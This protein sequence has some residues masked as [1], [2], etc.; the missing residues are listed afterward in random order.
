[1]ILYAVTIFLS[2]FLLFQVQPL[3]AK[4]IL[5]WFGG[6]SAVWSSCMLFF[7]VVLLGGYLYAHWLHEKLSPRWQAVVHTAV[8]GASLLVLPLNP[9]ASWKGEALRNPSW[10]ILG[11]LA[12]AIG[13]PYFVLSTTSPLIQAWYAKSHAGSVPYRLFALSNL[14]SLLALVSYPALVE[15]A[16]SL[17]HQSLA[18]SAGYA[19]FAV[20]CG[21]TGWRGLRG[22]LVEPPARS[23][24][25]DVPSPGWAP[26]LM[27]VLLPAVASVLLL[28]ITKFLTQDVAAVPFLWILPLA[29]YL[30]SFI[31]CFDSPR[32]YWRP[33][34]LALLVP[35]LGAMAYLDWPQGQWFKV[36]VTVSVSTLALFVFC[37]VC[38]GEMVRLKPHPRFLTGFYLMMSV[39]GAA[40]GVLVGMVAP[41]LFNAAYELPAGLAMCA[42]LVP[43]ALALE[44]RA[45]LRRPAGHLALAFGGLALGGYLYFLG[46]VV[47]DMV[48]GYRVVARNFYGE[49]R[50]EQYDDDETGPRRK[51]LHGIINHGE[52]IL[53]QAWRRS[54]ITYFCPDTGIG[55]AMR[56]LEGTP[57]RIGILGLGCGTL[58]TY[59][60]PGDVVRIYEIN[61]LV[62]DLAHREFTNIADAP[63][64]VET[65]LG[66]GR[67][68]LEREAPRKFDILVMDAFSGDSVPVHLI[69]R[70]AF[71]TYFR[72][73]RPGGILA[74]NIS[75]RY[76]DLKPV[77][78]RAARDVGRIALAFDYTADADD[79][80]CFSNTW[81]LVVEPETH[82]ALALIQTGEV[83]EPRPG[84]RAWTDDY[85]NLLGILK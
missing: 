66:D 10:A 19:G 52:Q 79:S 16:L 78:A 82:R 56:A 50:V 72:H 4:L 53:D 69:T 18:W 25:A 49:L 67:L 17:R 5:P 42:V 6:T 76:L 45:R 33:V 37:M 62:L 20:L 81:A 32:F 27:W 58:L 1:M 75:N 61:P 41:N 46:V 13:L 68:L 70:E 60:R 65:A 85:S 9:D 36:P 55:R 24:A 28:A 74:V 3:I 12:T 44:N 40:G 15:P 29:V 38:H 48:K 11:L 71:R 47:G 80:I 43:S 57:R 39:G 31:L 77:V 73:L 7:Q 63:A 2:A 59:S 8:L 26:R 14:A 51:L 22:R 34:F 83:I 54:P 84:F 30:L 64:R 35:A 23:A 21:V